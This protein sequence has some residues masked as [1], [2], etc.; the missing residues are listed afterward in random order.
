MQLAGGMEAS[1][2]LK[3]EKMHMQSKFEFMVMCHRKDIR[4]R[5][6]ALRVM[7]FGSSQARLKCMRVA[8]WCVHPPVTWPSP[9]WPLRA[10][11]R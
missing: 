9:C 1:R 11:S 6:S 7:V 2:Q 10:P 8:G 4:L 3:E 5:S